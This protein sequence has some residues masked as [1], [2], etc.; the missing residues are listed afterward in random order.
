MIRNLFYVAL[1]VLVIVVTL[2]V[3]RHYR[4]PGSMT[5]IESQAMDMS[6]M[7]APVGTMP[8]STAR[9]EEETFAPT[10]TYTGSVRAWS[11]EDVVAR[12]AGRVLKI[13]VY[14]G[15]RV[16]PGQLLVQL[17]S[18]EL[19]SRQAESAAA[20]QTARAKTTA[21]QASIRRSLSQIGAARK[22]VE[23]ATL[24]QRDANAE[25]HSSRANLDYWNAELKRTQALYDSDAVSLEEL[26]KTRA[27]TAK[28]RTE[29]HHKM[30]DISK[31]GAKK[32][33]ME[34]ALLGQG[35]GLGQAQAEQA[36]ALAAQSQQ[37]RTQKTAEIMQSYAM[38]TAPSKA[39]VTERLVSPGTLVMA[40]TVLLR[41]K[42]VDRLRLQVRVPASDAARI[43]A[44]S[45]VRYRVPDS[46][47]S[48]RQAVVTSVFH[49]ADPLTR[50]TTVEAIVRNSQLVPGDY[51]EMQLALGRPQEKLTVP[52]EAVQR[53]LEN[54][55]FVWLL[56]QQ[57]ASAHKHLWTCVMHPEIIREQ[58]GKC[59]KCGMDLVPKESP[60]Q[61]TPVAI[62]PPD[63]TCVM[64]PEI[65]SDKPGKCPK[66]GMD[67]VPRDKKGPLVVHR[68]MVTLKGRSQMRAAIAGEV[69]AG[70]EVVVTGAS[71]LSEGMSVSRASDPP[72]APSP[73]PAMDSSM[74]GMKM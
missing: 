5:V 55:P 25:E 72:P 32:A 48:W 21:A 3:V 28:A 43:R 40:G 69:T 64:H 57:G 66:C 44:G 23:I 33:Q 31:A 24:D 47:S 34:Q 9:V 67:L 54:R 22:D 37:E 45:P 14:P 1:L 27:D 7:A 71:N 51:I 38:I 49:E 62:A 16:V 6:A 13:A 10:V 15:D 50:T 70:D 36:A 12:I 63:Y 58:P 17:D 35:A 26:Q 60:A 52:L 56:E 20:T 46:G 74:P 18:D 19:A 30:L 29:Y 39:S 73:S 59:P 65:S 11:D 2:G 4:T 8:V 68:R 53:D 42:Q 61:A 41:L